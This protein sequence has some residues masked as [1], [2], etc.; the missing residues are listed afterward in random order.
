VTITATPGFGATFSGWSGACTGTSSTCSVQMAVAKSVTATFASSSPAGQ[1]LSLA[2]T[3]AGAVSA[4]GGVC[5]STN[6]KSKSCT[7]AYAT[8]TKVTLT[9]KPAAGYALSAWSG[10]CSGAKKTCVVTMTS[11]QTVGATFARPVLVAT[12]KPTVVKTKAGYRVTLW[13]HAG[14][15]G[16]LTVVAQRSGKTVAKRTVLVKAGGRHV[17]VTVATRGRYLVTLTL[18]GHA[19]RWRVTI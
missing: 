17:L 2:V 6:G 10:A 13:F 9:A 16:R 14:V 7:Q 18:A 12:Q 19:L 11:A 15:A 5:E 1:S 4:S 3:G 8:G